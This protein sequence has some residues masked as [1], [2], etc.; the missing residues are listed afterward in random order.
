[1][2]NQAAILIIEIISVVI[3]Q[4]QRRCLVSK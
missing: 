1:M 4:S 3:I 2:F